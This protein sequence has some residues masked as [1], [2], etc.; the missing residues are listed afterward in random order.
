MPAI[1][2]LIAD[3]HETFRRSVRALIQE[4]G[5]DWEIA[6]EVTDGKTA[7]AK[8]KELKPDVAILDI[9]MPGLNGLDA[10]KQ[11]VKLSP[12]TKVLISTLHPTNQLVQKILA[13]RACGY[14]LKTYAHRD[15]I[16]AVKAVLSNKTFFPG[17]PEIDA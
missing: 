14:I 7:V 8:A 2:L 17:H 1:R 6:A 5:P 13:A 3:D 11:I 10:A 4:Q 9:V 15:L 16:M 12:R